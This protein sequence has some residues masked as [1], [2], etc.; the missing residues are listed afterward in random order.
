LGTN[1]ETVAVL[2]NIK[3]AGFI[4]FQTRLL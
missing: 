3:G 1:N 2:S 4:D